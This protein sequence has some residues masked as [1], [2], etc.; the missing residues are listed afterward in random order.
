MLENQY[1]IIEQ[2]CSSIFSNIT[3]NANNYQFAISKNQE[4][5]NN[6]KN[7]NSELEKK[8]AI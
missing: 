2:D 1:N 5:F 8:L 3:N 7:I 4:E 6:L